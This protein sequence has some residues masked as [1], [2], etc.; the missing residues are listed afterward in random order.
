MAKTTTNFRFQSAK[1]R[2]DRSE[3]CVSQHRG[4]AGG[5]WSSQ[6]KEA[7]EEGPEVQSKESRQTINQRRSEPK[8]R[9]G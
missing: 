8:V 9:V 4:N 6:S 7:G 5:D 3:M 1:D 2:K